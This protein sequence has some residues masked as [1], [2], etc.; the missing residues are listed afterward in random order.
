MITEKMFFY[1][2]RFGYAC[3]SADLDRLNEHHK[4]VDNPTGISKP[5][6]VLEYFLHGHHSAND[7]SL[8]QLLSLIHSDRDS[9]R[10]TREAYF[11][12]RG[13]TFRALVFD[14]KGGM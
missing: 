8:I 10:K 14:K 9:E 12:T 2:G 3:W 11:I 13:N 4:P 5:T 1:R 7:I 6:T